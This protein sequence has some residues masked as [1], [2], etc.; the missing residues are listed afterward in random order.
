MI[1]LFITAAHAADPGLVVLAAASLTESLQKVGAAWTAAGHPGVT[2]SF[3]ASSRLAT[4]IEAGAPAD[5]Y[6][7]ADTAWMDELV[8]KGFVVKSTRVDLLGNTLVLVSPAAGGSVTD[9]ST[10]GRA[11]HLALAGESV[12]AGKYALAA[13]TALGVWDSVEDHVVRGD[14]VRT[15]LSWVA[16]GEADAGVVYG[17]DAKVEP[18]V[19]VVYTFPASSHPAIVYPAAVTTSSTHAADASAFLDYCRSAAGMAVFTAA[20]FSAPG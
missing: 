2:F 8:G 10:V 1:L 6:F 11:A 3:D 19:K 13:L 9:L 12:P 16:T 17:T 20:G 5:V 15:V 14:N 4:Q 7:S 18:R